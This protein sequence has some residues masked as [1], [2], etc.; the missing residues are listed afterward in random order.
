MGAPAPAALDPNNP[1]AAVAQPFKHPSAASAAVPAL[2]QP[3]RIEVDEGA[4]QQARSRARK[5][6]VVAGMLFAVVLGGLGW[7]GGGASQQ[8]SDRAKSA[9][10]AH[11]LAG[12]L[13][14]AK[15]SIDQMRDRVKAGG[16]TLMGEQKFPVDLAKELAAMHIDF[17]GDKLFGRRFAG[18]PA[19]TT[20]ALFEFIT[21]VQML[22][23]KKDLIVSLLNKLQAPIT[24]ELAHPGQMPVTLVAVVDSRVGDQGTAL[25]PLVKPIAP[26]D[27]AGVPEKLTFT[28]EGKNVTLQ[29]MTGDKVA[30][31]GVAIAVVP[32]SFDR[33]C[34]SPAK[35]QKLQLVTS[36]NSLIDDINGQKGDDSQ[37]IDAKPGLSEQAA[38][39][40]DSLNKVN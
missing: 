31:E 14:K 29:R 34:A 21:R 15:G 6:G 40:A 10:D 1:L 39:L 12:D 13:L 38:K 37:G 26:D 3:H 32:T 9:K 36:M 20:S 11:E 8:A 4:V 25:F 5:Q 33:V 27:R 17:A 30:K 16:T 35:G 28:K 24:E 18:V 22:N 19:D 2:V 23:D 7:V